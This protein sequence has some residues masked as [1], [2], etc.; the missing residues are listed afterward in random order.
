MLLGEGAAGIQGALW[1][2]ELLRPQSLQEAVEN[3]YL[4]FTE[5]KSE[6]RGRGTPPSPSLTCISAGGRYGMHTCN[7]GST[8]CWLWDLTASLGHLSAKWGR[9]VTKIDRGGIRRGPMIS[10]AV[11]TQLWW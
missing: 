5:G 1:P 10:L 8:T 3:G 7:C 11:V 4:H 2:S 9:V 6:A